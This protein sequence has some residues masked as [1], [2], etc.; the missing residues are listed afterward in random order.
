[1]VVLG[2]DSMPPYEEALK[3]MELGEQHVD[4]GYHGGRRVSRHGSFDGAGYSLLDEPRYA[5]KYYEF[6]REIVEKYKNDERIRSV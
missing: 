2:N 6:V 4:W 3:R 1:M 5:E